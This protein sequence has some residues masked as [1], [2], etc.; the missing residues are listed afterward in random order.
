MST[1]GTHVEVMQGGTTAADATSEQAWQDDAALR[2]AHIAGTIAET[3]VK[4]RARDQITQP[5][6]V[7]IRIETDGCPPKTS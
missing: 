5:A 7:H 1:D 2:Q 4:E 6:D 3:E